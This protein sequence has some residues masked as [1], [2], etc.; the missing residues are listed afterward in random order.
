MDQLIHQRDR[1]PAA[2]IYAQAVMRVPPLA[3]WEIQ[4][5]WAVPRA[6]GVEGVALLD[7]AERQRR[8][9]Y[10]RDADRDR[11]TTGVLLT[12]LV[13]AEHRGQPAESIRLDRRCTRCGGPHGR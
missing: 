5:W 8:S 1:Q 10:R 12:R 7:A 2:F 13:L 4:V 6:V 3:P 11:F 9:G